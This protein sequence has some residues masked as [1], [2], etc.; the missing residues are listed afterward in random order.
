MIGSAANGG[1]QGQ[2]CVCEK[3]DDHSHSRTQPNV[4]P[5]SPLDRTTDCQARDETNPGPCGCMGVVLTF[6]LL[7][8]SAFD[9][10]AAP[11]LARVVQL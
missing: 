9:P 1:A 2:Q 4:N 6:D 3:A 5:S 8:P 7:R 10:R 11:L